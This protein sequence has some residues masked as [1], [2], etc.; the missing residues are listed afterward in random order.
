MRCIALAQA[1]KKRGGVVTFISHC[2]NNKIS[3]RIESEGFNFVKIDKIWPDIQ[4]LK[5]TLKILNNFSYNKKNKA[6]GSYNWVVL[7]GYHFTPD[8]QKNIKAA[9]FKLLIIDDNNH[10]DHYYADIILNQN[11]GSDHYPYSCSQDTAKLLGT[12]YVMLRS[13]FL[14]NKHIKKTSPATVKNILVMMGGSD[15]DNVTLKIVQAI[16]KIDDSGFQFNI[17]VGP[18]NPNTTC[19]K[20]ASQNQFSKINLVHNADMPE[21]MAWADLCLTAGGSSCWELCFTQVPFVTIVIAQNQMELASGLEKSGVS[22]N[23]GKQETLKQD[24]ITHTILSLSCDIK[25][26]AALKKAG[27]K[28]VDGKGT[29]RIIR[30]MLDSKLILRHAGVKDIKLLYEQANDRKVRLSSV[31]SSPILWEEHLHW[32]KK[33]LKNENSWIFIAENSIGDPIGQIRFDKKNDLFEIS[34]SLDKRF[35]N[36]GLGKVLLEVGIKIIKTKIHEPVIMQG[37][38][39]HD[40][41][42]SKISF[43]NCGFTRLKNE[44]DISSDANYFIYQLLIHPTKQL[45]KS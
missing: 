24:D 30:H 3:N 17:I 4:D 18:D 8:Y 41:I 19:L 32:F 42:A 40:N 34:Y 13:E 1:W 43:E 23:L 25:K 35:R 2:P 7:D 27:I 20:D 11:I 10:L 22:L 12:K 44:L 28:I 39:K 6:S 26:R 31:N 5:K 14:M 45:E 29:K 15:P 16:N 33:K 36:L 9:G 21:M 37:L 38:I